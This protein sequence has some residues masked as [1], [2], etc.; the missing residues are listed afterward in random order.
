MR[1]S[2]FICLLLA[3]VTFAIY[4]RGIHNGFIVLDDYA[5]I[6]RNPNLPEGFSLSNIKW[7]FTSF[8]ASNWHP[9]TWLSLILDYRLY[10][11]NPAGY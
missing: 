6:V 7:V 5:Y 8:Y 1:K 3:I 4:Y 10:G 2:F 11:L 9:L